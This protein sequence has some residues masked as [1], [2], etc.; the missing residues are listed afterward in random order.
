M[1]SAHRFWSRCQRSTDHAPAAGTVHHRA[2]GHLLSEGQIFSGACTTQPA[3]AQTWRMT[4]RRAWGPRVSSPVGAAAAGRL[5]GCRNSQGCCSCSSRPARDLQRCQGFAAAAPR[6]LG[7]A[8]TV[9]SR[10]H[11]PTSI[12]PLLPFPQQ[13]N[14]CACCGAMPQASGAAGE[15]PLRRAA[16]A[17]H[18]LRTARH[19]SCRHPCLPPPPMLPGSSLAPTCQQ[20][21]AMGWAW[22]TPATGALPAGS[23]RSAVLAVAPPPLHSPLLT[24]FRHHAYTPKQAARLGRQLH[25]RPRGGAHRGHAPGARRPR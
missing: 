12:A 10:A 14:T 18:Q 22:R 24:A 19:R 9:F 17:E 4:G 2:C 3:C 8:A 6:R 7:R 16:A 21:S 23:A 11:E 1:S 20:C 15:T 13:C 5:S 25:R